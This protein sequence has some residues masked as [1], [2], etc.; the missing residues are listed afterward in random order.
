MGKKK[1]G[2]AGAAHG[3]SPVS[4]NKS[5]AAKVVVE[6]RKSVSASPHK[7]KRKTAQYGDNMST[8]NSP[9]HADHKTERMASESPSRGA[10][11]RSVRY[12]GNVERDSHNSTARGHGHSGSQRSIQSQGLRDHSREA[13][14]EKRAYKGSSFVMDEPTTVHVVNVERKSLLRDGAEHDGDGGDSNG[15][16]NSSQISPE[17]RRSDGGS[18]SRRT[19]RSKDG[20][21][22]TGARAQPKSRDV[23]TAMKA[24]DQD[25]VGSQ[26]SFGKSKTEGDERALGI[27]KT[28]STINVGKQKSLNLPQPATKK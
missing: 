26:Q 11:G 3:A 5:A 24:D 28:L 8:P 25:S 10:H 7:T 19:S 2:A 20:V 1:S 15:A 23:R 9:A 27:V 13:K 12:G 14:E 18:G 22:G 21:S 6:S 17:Q 16:V 4:K